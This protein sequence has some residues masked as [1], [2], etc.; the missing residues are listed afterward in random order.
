MVSDRRKPK[1]LET[2][3]ALPLGPAEIP[4]K[5]GGGGGSG[6]SLTAAHLLSSQEGLYSVE[7]VTETS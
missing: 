3:N 2:R 1:C 5:G 6:I 7:W 4:H